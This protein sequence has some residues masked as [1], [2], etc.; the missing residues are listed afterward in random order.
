MISTFKKSDM[1]LLQYAREWGTDKS[2]K[3]KTFR[4]LKWSMLRY[5]LKERAK[6]EDKLRIYNFHEV[7]KFKQLIGDLMMTS[8]QGEELKLLHDN[9][10]EDVRSVIKK[11]SRILFE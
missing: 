6:T 11:Y 8:N 9:H 5:E 3:K 10:K 7:K 2:A 1:E 4:W